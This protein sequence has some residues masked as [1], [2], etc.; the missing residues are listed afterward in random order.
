MV[1]GGIALPSLTVKSEQKLIHQFIY[2]F[3][4]DVSNNCLIVKRKEQMAPY[5]VNCHNYHLIQAKIELFDGCLRTE[6]RRMSFLRLFCSS[7]SSLAFAKHLYSATQNPS[8][9]IL[10]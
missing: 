3:V 4:V 7:S 9:F 10:Q 6:S 1:L 8:Q 5:R 2:D